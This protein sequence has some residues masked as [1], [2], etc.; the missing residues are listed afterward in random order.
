MIAAEQQRHQQVEIPRH[1]KY[2]GPYIIPP[3]VKPTHGNH[4][5]DTCG[6]MV[7]PDNRH[8]KKGKCRC[9]YYKRTT[10]WIDVIQDEFLLKRWMGR[11]IAWGMGQREDLQLSAATCRPDIDPLQTKEDK[12]T[13][14]DVAWA[15]SKWAGDDWKAG[16][17]TSE[18]KLT[19]MMDR[20]ETLGVIPERWRD[21]LKAYAEATKDIEWVAIEQFR[22]H[23]QL[24]VGG[25]VD[26]IGY[27]RN[28]R[29]GKLQVYDVKTGSD[30]NECGFA[31]QLAMYAHMIPYIVATDTRS[32]D[33]G[34]ID[35]NLGYVIKLPEGQGVCKI[36]PIHIGLGWGAC[37]VAMDVW[38][39]R[40]QKFFMPENE[41][42]KGRT[43]L[44]MARTAGTLTECKLLWRNSK[45][46]GEL[47][48][49]VKQALT[50]RA[51]ELQYDAVAK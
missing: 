5:C 12:D 11:N 27:K 26:R 33:P 39:L 17:G 22:V 38:K 24:K 47:T 44:D 42:R 35:L 34:V 43:L 19:H 31:M 40:K 9:I 32:V 10:K 50:T 23:D 7:E 46:M 36:E 13:L 28:R 2:G 30:W 48:D 8:P 15:A 1:P 45:A 41:I 16:I 49:D 3:G 6:R 51:N 4:R 37:K 14:N 29:D 25:T 20:G 18:H 21:D